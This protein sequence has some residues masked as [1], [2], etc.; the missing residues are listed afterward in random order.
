MIDMLNEL[1]ITRASAIINPISHSMLCVLAEDGHKY[2]IK[3]Y[4]S[5]HDEQLCIA[6]FLLTQSL[7]SNWKLNNAFVAGIHLHPELLKHFRPNFNERNIY[8]GIRSENGNIWMSQLLD[9]GHYWSYKAFKD[10]DHF[11]KIGLFDLWTLNQARTLNNPN[12]VLS[13]MRDGKMKIIPIN[14]RELLQ[15]LNSVNWNRTFSLSH[16]SSIFDFNLVK[17]TFYHLRNHRTKQDWN[18]YFQRSIDNTR[19]Q[20]TDIVKHI[21]ITTKVEKTIWN[22][23]YIFLFDNDR[24]ERVFSH[25]WNLVKR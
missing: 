24:N 23:L 20:F 6:S 25:F 12:L 21:N 22:Q 7:L 3:S 17:K 1:H 10:P 4:K 5:E 8:T 16:I 15:G 19:D 18:Q 9:D 11:L 2:H 13:P 14:H